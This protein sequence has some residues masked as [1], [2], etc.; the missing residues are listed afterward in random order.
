MNVIPNEF[1]ALARAYATIV[2]KAF[3]T[4]CYGVS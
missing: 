2:T 1:I 3:P 4:A